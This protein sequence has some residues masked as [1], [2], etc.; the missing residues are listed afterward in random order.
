MESILKC[1]IA[2]CD[3]EAQYSHQKIEIRIC[4]KHYQQDQQEYWIKITNIQE[5]QQALEVLQTCIKNFSVSTESEEYNSISLVKQLRDQAIQMQEKIGKAKE[6]N[7]VHKLQEIK[8]E[9]ANL[10]TQLRSNEDFK[11][12]CVQ[13]YMTLMCDYLKISKNKIDR[14]INTKI[15]VASLQEQLEQKEK[16]FTTLKKRFEEC[17]K[18][19]IN[20]V[21]TATQDKYEQCYKIITGKEVEISI[22]NNHI[23]S[24]GSECDVEFMESMGDHIIPNYK[25]LRIDKISCQISL[26]KK[27]IISSFPERVDKFHFNVKGKLIDC[28]QIS[29]LI[30]HTSFTG[31]SELCLYSLKI[32]QPQLQMLLQVICKNQTFLGLGYSKLSLDSVPALQHCLSG[33]KL[34]IL[35][36]FYCGGSECND[37]GK[38]PERFSNLIRALSQSVD[39]KKNFQQIRL[40]KCGMTKQHVRET[41]DKFGFQSIDIL[42]HSV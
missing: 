21:G 42:S 26:A 27:F 11:Q 38:Y 18:R 28:E 39:F 2:D 10:A 34:K 7:D 4:E 13:S 5:I 35:E 32:N 3:L 8:D 19:I 6:N 23:L 12:F 16:D 1:Q 30:I 29:D 9:A 36:L 14:L 20:T 40:E 37:W 24:C 22:S 15:D 25:S 41:L 17:R 33:S 31:L